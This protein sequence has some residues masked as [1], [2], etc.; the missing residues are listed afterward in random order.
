MTQL[1]FDEGVKSVLHHQH[2]IA[3]YDQL[4]E[5]LSDY[6]MS[7]YGDPTKKLTAEGCMDP[8][9]SEDALEEALGALTDLRED[10]VKA[11]QEIK[12][13]VFKKETKKSATKKKSKSKKASPKDKA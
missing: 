12:G 3:I 6:L 8:L 2:L 9:V 4:I 10:S 5:N 13:L 11:V 1:T 7:D